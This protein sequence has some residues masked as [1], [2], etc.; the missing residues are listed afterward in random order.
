MNQFVHNLALLA[1]LAALCAGLWQDWGLLVT[2]EKMV[3]SYLGGFILVA[4]MVLAVRAAA[5]PARVKD[6]GRAG[7]DNSAEANK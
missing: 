1:G 2:L 5:R 4:L 6:Q 7:S 3:I